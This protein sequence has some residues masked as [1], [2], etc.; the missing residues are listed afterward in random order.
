VAKGDRKNAQSPSTDVPRP[1][2]VTH[3]EL[4]SVERDLWSRLADAQDVVRSVSERVAALEARMDSVDQL[5]RAMEQIG[6][7]GYLPPG[8]DQAI[9]RVAHAAI[10][11]ALARHETSKHR[12]IVFSQI[13]E[14]DAGGS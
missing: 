3:G 9:E 11:R 6:V 5:V 14:S 4:A 2:P 8:W 7:G 13:D 12:A 1:A 10:T